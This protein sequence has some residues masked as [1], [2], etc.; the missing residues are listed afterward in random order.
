MLLHKIHP[1][2]TG[3]SLV[4]GVLILVVLSGLIGVGAWTYQRTNKSNDA[5]YVAPPPPVAESQ[6]APTG[7]TQDIVT[8]LTTSTEGESTVTTKA[9]GAEKFNAT[10]NATVLSQIG[11]SVNE[12]AY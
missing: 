11:D 12:T 5:A 8:D 9:F 3:F 7:S 2:E 4:E 10:A 6:K 1:S